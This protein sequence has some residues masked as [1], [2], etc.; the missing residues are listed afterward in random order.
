MNEKYIDLVT[1]YLQNT[2]NKQEH[3]KFDRLVETG[4]IDRT[5]LREWED[6]YHEMGMV[7][8][9]EPD[10]S[11]KEKFHAFLRSE[12]QKLE[13]GQQKKRAI[14]S[15]IRF[16]GTGQRLQWLW[17]SSATVWDNVQK[18]GRAVF[19][20]RRYAYVMG[21]FLTG[22]LTGIYL[23][24]RNHQEERIDRLTA[25]IYELQEMVMVSLLDNHS[26][27]ERLRA[28]NISMDIPPEDRRVAGAL[29]KTLNNDPNINV[30]LAAADALVRHASDPEVRIGLVESIS[31]QKSPIV[32]VA[33]ADV[34]LE[35]Q[36]PR[37]VEEFEKLLAD[38]EMNIHV[39]DKLENTIR[40]LKQS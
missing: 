11:M 20:I 6:L 30:R 2:L 4:E 13:A 28:V 17:E 23:A 19:E 32:Q 40:Q 18:T 15:R 39:R 16:S 34:M 26:A 24:D 38:N 33:L 8:V 35:L 10:P 21:I 3:R 31:R 36:E 22:L 1:G 37:A 5:M 27:V 12:Q 7:N 9:P 29:L 25:E 14:L